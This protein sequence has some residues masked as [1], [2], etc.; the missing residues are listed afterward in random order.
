[1]RLRRK[2]LPVLTEADVRRKMRPRTGNVKGDSDVMK[3]DRAIRLH[4]IKPIMAQLKGKPQ[5]V[6]P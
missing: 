6:M 4:Y 1:M 2:E 3:M 5:I